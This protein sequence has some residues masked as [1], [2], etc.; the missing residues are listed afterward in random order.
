MMCYWS[1]SLH[2]SA[3]GGIATPSEHQK[4]IHRESLFLKKQDPV[5]VQEWT[6]IPYHNMHLCSAIVV[7]LPY[8][9]M[10]STILQARCC[11]CF[12]TSTWEKQWSGSAHGPFLLALIT[13]NQWLWLH[14][15]HKVVLE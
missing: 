4:R 8:L 10:N 11:C 2:L 13:E 14:L 9:E 6:V 12:N 3:V 1:V 7:S 15:A 5:S